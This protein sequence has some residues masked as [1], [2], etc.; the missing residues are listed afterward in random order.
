MRALVDIK[1]RK[2]YKETNRTMSVPYFEVSHGCDGNDRQPDD[3]QGVEEG[4]DCQSKLSQDI[5][6]NVD[7]CKLPTQ[8]HEDVIAALDDQNLHQCA[9]PNSH[10]V[11]SESQVCNVSEQNIEVSFEFDVEWAD[12]PVISDLFVE[13]TEL[14]LSYKDENTKGKSPAAE[15]RR[16]EDTLPLEIS[17]YLKDPTRFHYS[18]Q[19]ARVQ[20]L[21]E[22]PRTAPV[23][24]AKSEIGSSSSQNASSYRQSELLRLASFADLPSSVPVYASRLAKSGFV[25]RSES[26]PPVVDCCFCGLQLPPQEFID[27]I[28]DILHKRKSPACPQVSSVVIENESQTAS[29]S[30]SALRENT[31]VSSGT[32]SVGTRHDTAS[33]YRPAVHP[34]PTV[35]GNV[36][37]DSTNFTYGALEVQTDSV[38][39]HT[40]PTDSTVTSASSATST[41]DKAVPFDMTSQP[42]T[43]SS[44][45]KNE[46]PKEKKKLTYADLGIF[47]E[48]PKRPEMA[49]V[50]K[51][52]QSFQGKWKATYTQTPPML[53]DAGMYYA[54]YGDCARCF[55]CGGGLKNWE[56]PD[57]PWIEH[58]R[59][60]PK[61]GYV[62]MSR[63]Q[64]FVDIVQKKNREKQEITLQEVEDEL[65]R[66]DEFKVTAPVSTAVPATDS[67]SG[68]ATGKDMHS[69][70][71]G[72]GETNLDALET[73]NEELKS[74]IMCKICMDEESAVVFLPCGHLVSC[75]HCS[76]ALRQ[77]PLCRAEIKGSVRAYMG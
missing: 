44:P 59:W 18:Y 37:A 49:V 13:G 36:T 68:L 17:I 39:T 75:T 16:D 5:V 47:A 9:L 10:I 7:G 54:G 55:F 74:E 43:P 31:Q 66:K 56:P 14:G 34:S 65:S 45:K 24:V 67:I 63:G 6:Q 35:Q 38:P 22:A 33:T 64:A 51:R 4:G 61:C 27:V 52:L 71:T 50:Q 23:S 72:Q 25:Y 12:L 28:P 2:R 73:E 76:H 57:S 11:I 40:A 20:M 70:A 3:F 53:A 1:T 41:R 46:P 26:D 29:D 60:F 42:V 21:H 62:R 8:C 58:A 69:H 32:L 30:A 19:N 15:S 77:C 48:K